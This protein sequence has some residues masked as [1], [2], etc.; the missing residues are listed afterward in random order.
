[1][2]SGIVKWFSAGRG[3]GF[4]TRADGAGD[5]FA[6]HSGILAD[7]YRYLVEGQ[8]VSFD[9]EPSERGPIAK[10]ISV[11]RESKTLGKLLSSEL[12]FGDIESRGLTFGELLVQEGL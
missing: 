10:N 2:D 11:V 9:T 8:E 7:G 4:I 5:V 3:Y 6:H 12:T 1:M